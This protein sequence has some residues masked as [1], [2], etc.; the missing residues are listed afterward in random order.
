M[1][2][3][4]LKRVYLKL[5]NSNDVRMFDLFLMFYIVEY[6]NFWTRLLSARMYPDMYPTSC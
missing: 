6:V 5:L 3:L 2:F 1:I 4:G